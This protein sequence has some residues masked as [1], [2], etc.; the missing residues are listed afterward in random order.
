MHADMMGFQKSV[1]Q[2][3]I[4]STEEGDSV[5]S[6]ARELQDTR[7][8]ALCSNCIFSETLTFQLLLT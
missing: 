8:M 7:F 3:G 6:Q 4:E 2:E 5:L 1:P